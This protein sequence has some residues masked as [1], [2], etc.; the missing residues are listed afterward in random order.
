MAS[1]P[2]STAYFTNLSHLYVCL[3]V[4]PIVDRQSLVKIFLI[5]TRQRLGKIIITATN[6]QAKI[7]EMLDASFSMRSDRIKESRQL[8]VVLLVTFCLNMVIDL[9]V[10]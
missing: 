9:H 6:I 3:Y 7:E 5:V 8:R 1:E 10:P 4:H 2:I